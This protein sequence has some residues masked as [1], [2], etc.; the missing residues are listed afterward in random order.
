MTLNFFFFFFSMRDA[1]ARLDN[2]WENLQKKKNRKHWHEMIHFH[3]PA[4]NQH[5]IDASC[6]SV[7]TAQ[8]ASL[9]LRNE[10]QGRYPP[11]LCVFLSYYSTKKSTA[12]VTKHTDQIKIKGKTWHLNVR[13]DKTSH[14][15]RG[16]LTCYQRG[17]PS[18][19][20]DNIK[21][22]ETQWEVCF[23][24]CSEALYSTGFLSKFN[25]NY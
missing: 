5:I 7:W 11:I 15:Y 3:W 25:I 17:E 19:G 4:E 20:T 1:P 2:S 14:Y 8:Q 22:C 12:P 13:R 21:P 16:D 9:Q 6:V 24:I 10:S 23:K 18:R